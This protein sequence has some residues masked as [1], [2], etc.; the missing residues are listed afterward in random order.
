M[1]K[2]NFYKSMVIFT[3]I[4]TFLFNIISSHPDIYYP[5]SQSRISRSLI[6]SSKLPPLPKWENILLKLTNPSSLIFFLL[7]SLL[8]FYHHNIFFT[9]TPNA[10]LIYLLFRIFNSFSNTISLRSSIK[11]CQKS[12]NKS[13]SNCSTCLFKSNFLKTVHYDPLVQYYNRIFS[14]FNFH[15]LPP[16]KKNNQNSD[17]VFIKTFLVMVDQKIPFATTLRQFLI[18]HPPLIVFLGF[19][20]KGSHPYFG[21]DPKITIPSDRHLRR[22]LASIQNSSLKL[23]LHDTVNSLHQLGILTDEVALDAAEIIAKVKE[24]NP[25]QFVRSRFNKNNIPQGNKDARLGVKPSSN[26][27]K[28]GKV[29][30]RF[31][32]GFKSHAAFQETAFGVIALNEHTTPAHIPDVKAFFTVIKPIT[33]TLHLTIKTFLADAA[34]DAWYVYQYIAQL[35]ALAFIPLNTR[36]HKILQNSFGKNGRPLCPDNREMTNAGGWFDKQKQHHR[37]KY[38]CPL[39]NPKTNKR[40]P[41][42]TCRCNHPNWQKKGCYKYINLDLPDNARFAIDRESKLFK[43]TYKDRTLAERGF[44]ILK[45]YNI[46]EPIF[47]NLNSIANIYTLAYCLMNAKVILKAKEETLSP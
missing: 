23:L 40:K 21:F 34:Y 35:G 36:G 17:V 32:W 24:N 18:N 37:Q 29:I 19:K 20:L 15:I 25:K 16:S 13:C 9:L 12:K 28:K 14:I 7:T 11:L 4:I 22:K 1:K 27:D 30:L 44:S 6:S 8:F 43:E 42:Q 41:G 26:K 47:R 46:E 45:D 5:I 31:F 33:E 38:I 39:I 3:T 10:V 2:K